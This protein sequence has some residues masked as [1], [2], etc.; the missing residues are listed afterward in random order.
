MNTLVIIGNGFDLAHGLPTKY[1]D[2]G[3][4]L[5][6]NPKY[7]D[8]YKLLTQ[9]ICFEDL[10]NSFE[11]ALGKI[12]REQIQ[13]DNSCYLVGYDDDD[14]SDSGHHDYQYMIEESLSFSSN[15]SQYLREWIESVDYKKSCKKISLPLD[16]NN[17]HNFFLSFNY[18]ATLEYLYDIDTNRILYIH[19]SINGEDELIVGHN[20]ASYL[21]EYVY[22]QGNDPRIDGAINIITNYFRITHKKIDEIIIKNNNFFEQLSN[23][24]NIYILGHS[25]SDVD[26]NYFKKIREK[27]KDD[28]KWSITFHD[29]K[30]NAIRLVNKLKVIHYELIRF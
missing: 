3:K 18:T 19:G 30:D 5:S 17:P 4:F 21:E 15:I 13:E 20:D 12:D 9:Y 22:L 1:S 27:V 25:L 2:F 6:K 16:I 7:A 24:N 29:N 11:D 28:C 14:W 23:I 8:F 10:W 26:F